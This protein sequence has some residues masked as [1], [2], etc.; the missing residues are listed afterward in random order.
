MISCDIEHVRCLFLMAGTAVVSCVLP[1]TRADFG[2]CGLL[3]PGAS[4]TSGFARGTPFFAAPEVA[5]RGV[6][7][8]TSDVY[9]FG[10]LMCE[11]RVLV[12]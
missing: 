3:D 12:L 2:L 9:G 5:G 6:A 10:V 8:D 4:H 1:R 7:T 11:W